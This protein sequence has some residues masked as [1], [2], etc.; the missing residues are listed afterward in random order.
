VLF[1]FFFL[2][3]PPIFE[4]VFPSLFLCVWLLVVVGCRKEEE[5]RQLSVRFLGHLSSSLPFSPPLFFSCVW[6]VHFGLQKGGGVEAAVGAHVGPSQFLSFPLFLYPPLF[7]SGV[8]KGGGAAAA[9]SALPGP[10]HFPLLNFYFLF[11]FPYFLGCRKEEELRQLSV[12]F[13][14]HKTE[15]VRGPQT[16]VSSKI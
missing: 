14:G 3:P 13:L 15:V 6:G 4:H 1:F 12:R 9:V 2:S 8:Q 11:F 10:S 16:Q 7:F 5:L